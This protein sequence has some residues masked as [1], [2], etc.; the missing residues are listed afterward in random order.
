MAT[1]SRFAG[2][3]ASDNLVVNNIVGA[4]TGLTDTLANLR[5]GIYLNGA[6]NNKIGDTAVDS[7]NIVAGNLQHGIRIDGAD[8]SGNEVRSNRIG[9]DDT[10]TATNLGNGGSGVYIGGDA[11]G[12]SLGAV[13]A[14]TPS[15]NVIFHNGADG[16]TIVGSGSVGNRV[17]GN[18]IDLNGGL[19]IDLDDDG[20]GAAAANNGQAAPALSAAQS[21][22]AP[23]DPQTMVSGS[24]P[25]PGGPFRIEVFHSPACDASG[26]G[27]GRTFVGAV[28]GV[29]AGAFMFTFPLE[30]PVGR[31]VTAT[32]TDPSGNTS[33]FS[34][35]EQVTAK[36][37]P[38]PTPT[39]TD[40]LT[41]IP[42]DTPTPAPTLTPANTPTPLP[43]DPTLVAAAAQDAYV[44]SSSPSSNYGSASYLRLRDASPSYRTYIQFQ[45]S[46]LSGTP[47]RATLRLYAY[48][49]S[50]SGGDVYSVANSW[51]ES[52]ITWNNAPA[53]SGPALD[54]LGAVA[55]DTWAEYDVTDAVTGNGT[56]SFAVQN[57]STNSLYLRSREGASNP[58]ELVI[59]YYAGP[60][61]TPSVT[62][63]ASNTPAPI[64]HDCPIGHAN[65]VQHASPLGHDGAVGHA[66]SHPHA[67][68]DPDAELHPDAEHDPHRLRDASGDGDTGG[69]GVRGQRRRLRQEQLA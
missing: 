1:A 19:G 58:P 2:A 33:E 24:M 34:A 29:A 63:S 14:V 55:D 17:L 5:S 28:D 37:T 57:S 16:V 56:Y 44:K 39:A 50:N 4:T 11:S 40:T 26:Y 67:E 61:A 54:S 22:G 18:A 46:S 25:G 8:A 69:A 52:G 15:I 42:S 10:T 49:G 21:L 53:I 13:G 31:F 66:D 48:D 68:H 47:W 36:P 32:A 59:D 3:T 6:P 23:F 43:P 41:P 51:T 65:G 38:T 7:G 60:T 64:G 30:V 9:T 35:C 20:P 27:E 45:V 12:N 62:P